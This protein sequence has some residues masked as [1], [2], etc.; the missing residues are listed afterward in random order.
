MEGDTSKFT[1]SKY[2]AK[3]HESKEKYVTQ[4]KRFREGFM[5]K[6]TQN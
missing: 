2:V 1:L 6:T 5:E 4:P 3:I